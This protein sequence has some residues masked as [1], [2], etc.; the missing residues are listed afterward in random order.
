MHAPIRLSAALLALSLAAAPAFA[1]G[2]APIQPEAAWRAW[3]FDPLVLAPLLLTHWLYGRGVLRLWARAGRGRGVGW[4]NVFAFVLGEIALLAAL[5]SPLDALSGTLLS[6]HMTQH[7]VLIAVA[8][9][10][11]LLG[12]PG[13]A[14]GWALPRR[15]RK[16]GLAI[17]LW[18]PL[19]RLGQGLSRPWPAAALHGLALW[20]WHAPTL[21][22]MAIEQEWLHVLEHAAFFGT[23]LLF[24]RA[25]LD[26]AAGRRVGAAL[27][28]AF[29]TLAHGGLLGALITFAPQPLYGWY[30][31]RTA[32]W[33]LTALEDQQLAGLI[34]WTP[35]GA[36]YLGA[37]LLV[38]SR[39]LFSAGSETPTA[40]AQQDHAGR[41]AVG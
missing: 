16:A 40:S 25:T 26:G 3:S 11:L 4:G 2:P 28:G 20:A 8:P 17:A 21:F 10:L 22:E 36:A 14:F 31:G 1:H 33:G 13:A 34:M 39:L 24:W 12:R 27:G 29:A 15:W 37:C 7:G 9:P 30:D 38:A 6:A 19:A 23:G 41:G 32:L 35:L 18:R 5:A